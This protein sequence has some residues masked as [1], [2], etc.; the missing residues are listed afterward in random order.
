MYLGDMQVPQMSLRFTPSS[1]VAGLGVFALLGLVLLFSACAKTRYGLSDVEVVRRVASNEC[2]MSDLKDA[3][4][5]LG[6]W[7]NG[8]V[9]YIQYPD[10][11]YGLTP[12][13][14]VQI[15]S[16]TA[17]FLVPRMLQRIESL[18]LTLDSA[19]IEV[20]NDS[21]DYLRTIT[22]KQ[23][24]L[25]S[26][27]LPIYEPG[28]EGEALDHLLAINYLLANQD[29]QK[30]QGKYRFDHWNYTLAAEA[31]SSRA[32]GLQDLRPK[33]LAYTDQLPDS[34]RSALAATRARVVAPHERQ[35]PDLF[36]LSTAGV[37]SVDDLL[38]L[39]DSLSRA[40]L[41][42]MPVSHTVPDREQTRVIPGW[43]QLG[44]QRGTHVYVNS[45]ITRRY[46]AAV[47]YYPHTQTAV[48][49]VCADSKRLDCLVVD[50]L[51]N[52]NT[53]WQRQAKD[54]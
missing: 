29:Q 40:D 15:G 2:V 24:L 38:Q 31:L 9:R 23:L 43:Y 34:V 45:G 41:E 8:V 13:T 33:Q 18:G 32:G 50:I 3:P 35:R 4:L 54:E 10:S 28:P 6:L 52:L 48:V 51:R 42:A 5:L 30:V 47:A 14:P 12:A 44:L 26:S 19:A 27:D 20:R 16:L 1:V 46:G 11:T 21:G 22:Y 49:A 37:A 39:V 25:H 36:A 7:D 17:S 53:N